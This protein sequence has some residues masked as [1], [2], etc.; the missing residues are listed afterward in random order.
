MVKEYLAGHLRSEEIIEIMVLSP[1]G[2]QSSRENSKCS[3]PKV[4]MNSVCLKD[5]MAGAQSASSGKI[6]NEVRK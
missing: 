2:Q 3:S 5:S 6:G 4:E 1:G